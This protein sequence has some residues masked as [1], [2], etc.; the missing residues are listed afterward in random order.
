MPGRFRRDGEARTEQNN[1]A[2]DKRRTVMTDAGV[3]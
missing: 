1:Q 3:T 2:R